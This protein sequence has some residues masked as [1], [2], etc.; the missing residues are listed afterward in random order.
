MHSAN[1]LPG[2]LQNG[3]QDMGDV[4]ES[5]LA[6]DAQKIR[7]ANG[8]Q[9][10]CCSVSTLVKR[11]DPHLYPVEN[12]KEDRK[13]M[14]FL[15]IRLLDWRRGVRGWVEMCRWRAGLWVSVPAA[16]PDT[17]TSRFEIVQR[18][19]SILEPP[20]IQAHGFDRLGML[21]SVEAEFEPTR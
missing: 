19:R 8:K 15:D 3:S 17:V 16:L 5:A 4:A 18:V 11:R 9:S 12:R 13:V 1:N 6:L 21:S 20:S 14:G 10:D 7:L 2:I